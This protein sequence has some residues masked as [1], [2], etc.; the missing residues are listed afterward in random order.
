MTAA[1]GRY[2]IVLTVVLCYTFGALVLWVSRRAE[3]DGEEDQDIGMRLRQ[4]SIG[5]KM[6]VVVPVHD[7]DKLR[8]MDAISRWPHD[9]HRNTL[10]NMDLVIYKAEP[11]Q[12]GPDGDADLLSKVPHEASTC[13]RSI[14][15]VSANLLP[16]VSPAMLAS[17][18]GIELASLI[19]DLGRVKLVLRPA[20]HYGPWYTLTVLV[21]ISGPSTTTHSRIHRLMF[22]K[23]KRTNGSLNQLGFCDEPSAYVT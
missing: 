17:T 12:G 1:I 7:G 20:D 3:G 10:E 15:I 5:R 18:R 21:S 8:A 9:R 23:M 2:H 13:F 4:G 16:E 6:A 22:Q 19:M 14:K 11:P